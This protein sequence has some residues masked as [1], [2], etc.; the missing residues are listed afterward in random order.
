MDDENQTYNQLPPEENQINSEEE[1]NT[2]SP[3]ESII[4]TIFQHKK[5]MVF[6]VVGFVLLLTVGIVSTSSLKPSPSD[7]QPTVVPPTP[8]DEEIPVNTETTITPSEIVPTEQPTPTPNESKEAVEIK[9]Q[10]KPQIEQNVA[11]PYEVSRVKVYQN[12]W[13]LTQLYMPS[14]GYANVIL[15]KEGNSWK[16]VS[17]PGSYFSPEELNKIGAPQALK[18]DINGVAF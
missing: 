14:A 8:A 10:M 2:A 18:D 11:G 1:Q 7:I 16:V 6:F 13:S 17:G 15:K 12:I 3:Q 4:N 5:L 9:T